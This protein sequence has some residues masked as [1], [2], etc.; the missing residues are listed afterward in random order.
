M[1]LKEIKNSLDNNKTLK[2]IFGFFK[3][4]LY[5]FVVLLLVI[6][7]VQKISKNNIAVGGYRIFTVA[8]LSMKGEYDIGDILV[9]KSVEPKD[10]VLND[11][12]TYLGNQ[13]DMYGLVI[14]HKLIK[15]EERDG[16]TYYTTKGIANSIED[17]EITFGQIYGKV[18]MKLSILSKVSVIMS[19][20]FVYYGLFVFIVLL[21]S[22]E[23]VS[24]MFDKRKDD[25][26]G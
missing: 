21:V 15:V 20:R 2:F 9:V 26:D 18:I 3:F 14:T 12:I 16:V 8:S 4:C 5:A 23:V 24:S 19:N 11:N 10:L 13:E 22:I 6:I 7:I 25:V 1:K 17:P